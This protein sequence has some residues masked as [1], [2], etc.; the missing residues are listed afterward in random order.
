MPFRAPD[1]GYLG[2][3]GA[4]DS[5][6]GRVCDYEERM[7]NSQVQQ[8]LGA[9][10]M[11]RE[12]GF[13]VI[14]FPPSVPGRPIG[15]R[16]KDWGCMV[17]PD[18]FE[19]EVAGEGTREDWDAQWKTIHPHRDDVENPAEPGARFYRAKLVRAESANS[20]PRFAAGE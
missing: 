10:K 5:L 20:G 2:I 14:G 18:G 9:R 15:A 11:M 6:R 16:L 12:F 19:I 7:T 1:T 8:M 13:V 4:G 17:M 3:P